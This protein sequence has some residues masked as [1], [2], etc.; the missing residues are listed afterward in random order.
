M[1]YQ[2]SDQ[3]KRPILIAVGI[4][5]PLLFAIFMGSTY[6][7]LNRQI[8]DKVRDQLAGVRNLMAAMEEEDLA[9]MGGTIEA[10]QTDE[11][12]AQAVAA[13]DRGAVERIARRNFSKM[14][15]TYTINSFMIMDGAGDSLMEGPGQLF[16]DRRVSWVA[17]E[18]AARRAPASGVE[19]TPAGVLVLR[20][21]RPWFKDG[22]LLGYIEA[23]I[24]LD[25][26]VERL[27]RVLNVEL[28]IFIAKKELDE[29]AWLKGQGAEGRQ[30]WGQLAHY[31][32]MRQSLEN[33]PPSLVG[34][35]REVVD[36][37]DD[38]HPDSLPRAR[39]ESSTYRAG[40]LPVIDS[41]GRDVGDITMVVD[42]TR[43]ER[44]MGRIA[45]L[46]VVACLLLGGGLLTVFNLFLN[47]IQTR[48]TLSRQAL[49]A[50]IAERAQ[51]EERLGQQKE[52]LNSVIDSISHPFY[53]INVVS[54]QVTL[55]N[56]ASGIL[57]FPDGVTCYQLSHHRELPCGDDDHPCTIDQIMATGGSVVLEHAHYDED[58]HC[59]YIEI[60]G[61]PVFDRQGRIVRVIEHCMDIT[62]RKLAETNLRQ[63]KIAAEEAS[64]AKGQFLANMSHEIRT[65]MNGILGFTELLMGM[66]MPG[67]Q[68]EYLGLIKRSADRLLDIV[69][70]I[71]DFSKME[72]GRIEL[73]SEP[74]SLAQLMIDS[75]GVLAAKAQ[76]K[77][78]EL[79]YSV[80]RGLPAVLIGDPGRLRQV[81]LN[82]VGNAIKFT[83]QGEI[84]VRVERSGKTYPG[85]E[86]LGVKFSVRDTGAGVPE[87]QQK[88]IFD[89]FSQGDGSFSRR[90]GGTG[91]GLAI[92]EQLVTLMGG[93][94][95]VDSEP[96]RGSVFSFT[97]RL[98]PG[99]A[100]NLE[101]PAEEGLRGQ[102]VLIVDDHPTCRRVLAQALEGTAA[103]VETADSPAQAL[104][105]L[106]EEKF[107]VVVVDETLPGD[108]GWQLA[109]QL[110]RPL[111]MLHGAV[112][113]REAGPDF[114][115]GRPLVWLC[116]PVGREALLAAIAQ[117]RAGG[118][119][120]ALAGGPV[121][122]DPPALRRG[123]GRIL[124]VEDDQINQALALALLEEQGYQ[125]VAA[126]SG[127]KALRAVE[128]GQFDVVLMDVQLPEM[129]GFE[130]TRRIRAQEADGGRHL[131]IIAM[132]A[133]AMP[134][135]RERC[136]AA[137]MDDFVTKPVNPELLFAAIDRFLSGP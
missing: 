72:A 40:T 85:G 21:V 119:G 42:V 132:T 98:M 49:R 8:T 84:E 110:D 100:A 26:I 76:E 45:L 137:G 60:H 135:D 17:Q 89:T 74:F 19:L 99:A 38:R 16:G 34:F 11:A 108:G 43:Y 3:I 62:L 9:E 116:K 126:D 91:L 129:D 18:A 92:C 127:G 55:A 7:L 47:R 121:A 125:V 59:R 2:S 133:H 27:H 69:N 57:N 61:Y 81:L 31:V 130:I 28:S 58:G 51:A 75:V 63:A 124:L 94:I 39:I 36:A 86:G 65:P 131:A 13:K 80:S 35:L 25:G 50:E 82:L 56:K 6:N 93:R 53:V 117:A 5:F 123:Q 134:Q 77:G 90:H 71:L 54:R 37:A 102:A 73:T 78:L 79:V 12:L 48:L 66:E 128:E 122:G 41:R 22:E 101:S 68:R 14:L 107:A 10:V 70:D 115:R 46:M 88:L 118:G 64:R 24:R 32:L 109:R 1:P 30:A 87:E 67:P 23:G 29:T 103:R 20:M 105:R 96:G 112:R 120:S 97:T 111:V 33:L 15:G 106:A 104:E 83:D 52:F 136:L 44:E 113:G 95:W 4:A 114:L